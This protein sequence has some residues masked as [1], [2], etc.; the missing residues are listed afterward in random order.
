MR[1]ATS[2]LAGCSRLRISIHAPH[3]RSDGRG[4]SITLLTPFQSTLLMRGATPVLRSA[5][6]VFLFQSTLLMRGATALSTQDEP[7]YFISIHAPHARSDFARVGQEIFGLEFQSTL[8]MR[9]ATRLGENGRR[10][11]QISIHAPHARSDPTSCGRRVTNLFQ[12]TLL[13]RGATPRRPAQV[14]KLERNFN[15]RSSCEERRRGLVGKK[16]KMRFQSTLLMRGATR[17]VVVIKWWWRQFQS[18]LLMRGATWSSWP[19]ATKRPNFNPRSSCEERRRIGKWLHPR[20][21]SIHAP[22]ARSDE[23]VLVLAHPSALAISIHAPHARSDLAVV[24][25]VLV[26]DISIHAPHARSD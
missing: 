22:H 15:P 10:R 14:H 20:Q 16:S 6:E 11:S 19:R 23:D 24:Q 26:H 5:L 17:R 25:A 18:T 1:G 7:L 8:L 3:A 13:M 2:A 12:S 21:I 9:G 4:G